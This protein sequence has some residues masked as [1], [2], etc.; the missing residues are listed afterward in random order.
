MTAHDGFTLNDLVSYNGKHNEANGEGNR[1]GTDDNL[2]WNCGVEGD[3]DDAG[4][5]DLRARQVRNFLTILM[6]SQGVPMMVMGDEARQTQFGNNNA[7]CQDN[8][9]TWFDWGLADRHADLIRFT[10]DLIAFR[11]EHPTL[12]RARYFIGEVND[13]GVA[14][15]AWHGC[16]LFS[17]GWNDPESRVLAFTLGGFPGTSSASDT[18]IHVMMNM[19][20]TDLDFDIP[21]VA[22][23]RWHRAIDTG[24]ASA[25]GH[26]R[27]GP[28][29]ARVR[30]HVPGQEPKRRGAHLQAVNQTATRDRPGRRTS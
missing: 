24:A 3:T 4:I 22:G 30:R 11:K 15:L 25:G 21:A 23:R 18:D 20:W 28:R 7:Y 9:I 6:L 1:D 5:L 10:S 14:D 16:R 2:S 29:G 27:Q 12:R 19:D 17:P 13:R 26:L 8:E